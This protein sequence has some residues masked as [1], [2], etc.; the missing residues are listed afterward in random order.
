MGE[1]FQELE[2]VGYTLNK[3]VSMEDH[4]KTNPHSLY[5]YINGKR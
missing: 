2:S 5:K 3:K 1:T 4:I